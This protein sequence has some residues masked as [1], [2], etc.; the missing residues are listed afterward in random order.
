MLG[1]PSPAQGFTE[2]E[3]NLYM[4]IYSYLYILVQIFLYNFYTD[5]LRCCPENLH[6]A[7]V[8]VVA[9]D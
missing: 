1:C 9:P 7:A 3:V 6:R 8:V 2:E 4:E 5:R